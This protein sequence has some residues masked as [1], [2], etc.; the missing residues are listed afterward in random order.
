MT[1]EKIN[2]PNGSG[3]ISRWQTDQ[4]KISHASTFFQAPTSFPASKS[5]EN[6][7]LHFGLQGNYDFSHRQLRKK[8]VGVGGRHNLM[9][10]KGFDILVETKSEKIETFGVEFPKELFINISEKANDQL[11]IFCDAV[12]NGESVLLSPNWQTVSLEMRQ[13]ILEIRNSRYV[14]SM[15][16]LFLFSKSLE[17]LVL[18]AESHF[19]HENEAS[20]FIKTPADRE[21]INAAY[22]IISQQIQSPP[23]LTTLAKLVGINEYKLKRGFKETFNT[24]VYGY[25]RQRRL[26]LAAKYLRDTQKT[27]AEISTILGYSSP[28]HFNTAFKNFFGRTPADIRKNP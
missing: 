23:N 25:I 24:T 14:G 17:L 6:V 28:Q 3:L 15:Q 20:Q 13:V 11:K 21:K 12:L 18:S 16:E 5:D 22:E 27:A 8:Y 9:F 10:S 26:E 7:R 4:I 19:H 1:T 2:F